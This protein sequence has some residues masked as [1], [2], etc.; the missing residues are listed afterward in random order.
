MDKMMMNFI[1][2][3][4]SGQREPSGSGNGNNRRESRRRVRV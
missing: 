2:D 3:I 4:N 1:S